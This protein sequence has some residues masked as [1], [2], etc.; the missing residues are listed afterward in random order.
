[1]FQKVDLKQRL[2]SALQYIL[3]HES[4]LLPEDKLELE[5]SIKKVLKASFRDSVA[6]YKKLSQIVTLILQ[7][8][9]VTIENRRP[10][11]DLLYDSIQA[12]MIA[13]IPGFP[14]LK[15]H[16]FEKLCDKAYREI[17]TDRDKQPNIPH[18]PSR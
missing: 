14:A 5:L 17:E 6:N 11:V 10:L 8:I 12:Q 15:R 4:S 7:D 18:N 9:P 16:E 3:R 1:M 2:I 13:E